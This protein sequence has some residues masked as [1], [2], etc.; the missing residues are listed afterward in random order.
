M[1]RV[2]IKQSDESRSSTTTMT[3]DSELTV[4]LAAGTTYFIE[5][6]IVANSGATPDL[7]YSF[8]YTGT[9]TDAATFESAGDAA[10]PNTG[11]AGDSL[12]P[13][14]SL[15]GSNLITPRVRTR[16]GSNTAGTLEVGHIRG[17]LITNTAGNLK[18]QWA[19]NTSDASNTTVY[20]GSYISIATQADMDGT[21]IIKG[22]STST[23]SNT[24]LT[25]DPDLQFA[26]GANKKYIVELFSVFDS[27]TTEDCKTALHDANVSLSAGHCMSNDLHTIDTFSG[28]TDTIIQGQ[29]R[30]ASFVT[31]PTS[32]NL[33]TSV[34][35]NKSSRNILAAH[36]M[37][38]SGG[39]LTWEWAQVTSSATALFLRAPCWMLYQDVT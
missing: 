16:N 29:W 27:N 33:N 12:A 38:G 15:G 3:D 5:A 17:V 39:T 8:V 36:Q 6:M 26:T 35:A 14:H 9:L 21:L 28:G 22:S 13:C 1:M 11:G 10:A 19:Q 30:N 24:T 32:G 25:A 37:G 2:K 31:T 4:A 18:I 23:T 7:K 34:T 20:K